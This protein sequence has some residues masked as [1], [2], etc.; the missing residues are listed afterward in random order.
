M[1]DRKRASMSEIPSATS[2]APNLASPRSKP[3]ALSLTPELVALCYREEVDPGLNARFTPM[4]DEDYRALALD[5]DAQSGG[6]P[7]W[8]FAYGSLIWK[9]E[10]CSVESRR[11]TAYG[12]HRAFSL[13]ID[14]W[15]GSRAAP[16]L[17]MALEHGGRCDGVIYRLADGDRIA[18]I[19][20]LLRRELSSRE[21]VSTV[22][23]MPVRT[24][25]GPVN[26]LGFWLGSTGH[27]AVSRLPLEEVARIL[28]RACGHVG[29][30]AE[31]LYN[32]VLHLEAV[33]IHDRNLW[34][35]QALV[36]D[37]IRKLYG[38]H[39]AAQPLSGETKAA[40]DATPVVKISGEKARDPV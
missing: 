14:R 20:R 16:G 9:P 37:E 13:K 19:E 8:V 40:L 30:C 32:T 3:R 22:R 33:G 28:A 31:Y 12:W 1:S 39:S 35:L 38:D 29:S 36:A 2:P 27:D 34:R 23:W 24:P 7:L 26:V 5:L 4:E 15:R 10:F 17:M 25:E 18:Q 11:A 21:T 6:A